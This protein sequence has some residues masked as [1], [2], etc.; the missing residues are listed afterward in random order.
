MKTTV[1]IPSLSYVNLTEKEGDAYV[2]AF[3]GQLAQA[4]GA[5]VLTRTQLTQILGAERQRQL[6]GCEGGTNCLAEIGDAIGA[7][8][9]ITGSLGKLGAVFTVS[10]KL[11]RSQST[12]SLTSFSARA[13][14]ESQLL[15]VLAEGARQFGRALGG[16]AAP[17]ATL[18]APRSVRYGPRLWVPAGLTVGFGIAGAVALG[19]NRGAVASLQNDTFADRA[20][21]DAVSA[22]AQWGR[23]LGVGFL[24]AAAVSLAATVV[25]FL[26]PEPVQSTLVALAQGAP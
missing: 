16:E 13:E 7:G 15:D 18:E 25:L 21:I 1:A 5:E 4:C 20:A 19:I 6:A 9:I 8:H 2:D 10:L 22:R 12:Q 14:T 17:A 23:N 11:V 3:A 26:L 24:T